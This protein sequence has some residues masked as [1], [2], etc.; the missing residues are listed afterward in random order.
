[1]VSIKDVARLAGVSTATVSRALANPEKVAKT[2]REKVD[3]AVS[4]S[5]YVANT[6]ARNFRRKRTNI[7]LVLVPDISNPFFSGIIRGIER[8]ALRHQY[9]ILLGDTQY[10]A[11]REKAY[12]SL[13]SQRQADGIIGLGMSIP[14]YYRKGRKTIDPKWPPFIMACE[15]DGQIPVP[16][17]RIDNHRAAEDAT[18]HLIALGHKNIAFINGPSASPLCRDRLSGFQHALSSSG[19]GSLKEWIRNG[20]FSLES[21]R[22]SMSAIL[23]SHRKPSAIF[24]ANDEMAI[25]AMLSAREHGLDIPDDLSIIGFDDISFSAYTQPPLTTV[26][27]PRERIGERAME[28]M[29]TAL[30]NPKSRPQHVILEHE[31]IIRE[32]TASPREISRGA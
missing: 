23:Q 13:V 2:T 25:G 5:G 29:L 16:S 12:A 6:L 3:R 27:Q 30:N 20:D 24:C 10:E 22:S 4:E 21:G 11:A 9:R 18:R 1:M 32:S 14:F 26:R 28:M 17:V 15:Y 8:I 31:L 19:L 7:V